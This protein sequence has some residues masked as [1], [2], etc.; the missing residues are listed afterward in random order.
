MANGQ[1]ERHKELHPHK[2]LCDIPVVAVVEVLEQRLISEAERKSLWKVGDGGLFGSYGTDLESFQREEI[3]RFRYLCITAVLA[4]AACATAPKSAEDRMALKQDADAALSKAQAADWTLN[5]L[6]R[7]SYGY[8]I[9]PSVGKGGFGVGGAYGQGILYEQGE[10]AGY[11]DLTQAS[12]GFQLGGQTYTEIIIFENKEA[13]DYFKSGNF[14]FDAQVTAVALKSGAGA[15]AKY[16][17]G[18]AIFTMDEGG[19]MY[20]AS[21]GGQKFSY[22]AK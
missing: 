20:E 16:S 13:T 15:N 21:V 4:I 2:T 3:M 9:F 18:V 14:A 1:R 10:F 8:A 5:D 6:V 22:Q 7:A 11:C 12:I 17:A 19:L